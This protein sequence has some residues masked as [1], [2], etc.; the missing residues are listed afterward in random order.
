MV[1]TANTNDVTGAVQP[2][3]QFVESSNKT[4]APGLAT[5]H[6][7]RINIR[8]V[9]LTEFHYAIKNHTK[10]A[11]FQMLRPE[12]T[13]TNAPHGRCH[14]IT[15]RRPRGYPYEHQRF[16]QTREGEHNKIFCSPTH[17]GIS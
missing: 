11:E 12:D 13:K 5:A 16:D 7:K 8:M 9:N 6:R 15:A 4:V 10:L 2:L 14:T 17:K 3:P 1:N